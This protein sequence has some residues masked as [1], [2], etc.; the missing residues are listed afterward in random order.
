MNE[1]FPETPPEAMDRMM[2]NRGPAGG[3]GNTELEA[4]ATEPDY[5]TALSQPISGG[6][7]ALA[8][9]VAP[10]GDASP[11]TLEQGGVSMPVAS[12]FHSERVQTE[13][14]LLRRRPM[15]L[16][17]DA[18]R[19]GLHLDEADLGEEFSA[20]RAREPPYER[21]LASGEAPVR[22]ARL[23]QSIEVEQRSSGGRAAENPAS[24]AGLRE[25]T[26]ALVTDSTARDPVG[27]P[28]TP[29]GRCDH[30]GWRRTEREV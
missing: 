25:A 24:G 29:L 7:P 23:E 12:P 6:D 11:G 15:T 17:Q 27:F 2:R 3:A 26:S 30:G 8:K 4:E 18:Q 13:V 20:A 9:G 22:V 16:D 5:S 14:E 10:R 1:G 19:V 28:A 21:E